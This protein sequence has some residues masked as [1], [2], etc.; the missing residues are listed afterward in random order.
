M[1]PVNP[2]LR[3]TQRFVR[4]DSGPTAVEYAILLALLVLVAVAAIGGI[5]S[6]VI[7]I[8]NMIDGAM[9]EGF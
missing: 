9:P 1:P 8:Y 4:D 2:W 5:G 7:N 3:I 6:R